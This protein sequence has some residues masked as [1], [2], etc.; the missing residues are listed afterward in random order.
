[1][2]FMSSTEVRVETVPLDPSGNRQIGAKRYGTA[3]LRD[4]K[5]DIEAAV[6]EAVA[7][8]QES[9]A[10]SADAP[11]WHV[12]SLEAK[13]GITLT[14]EAGVLVSRA[15]VEASFEITISIERI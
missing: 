6:H 3:L 1:M 5:A 8:M 12:R 14:G 7:I 13:F 4:R 2:G 9:A 10:N 11:G 15:S